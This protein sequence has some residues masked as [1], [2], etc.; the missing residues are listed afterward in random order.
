MPTWVTHMMI[1]DKVLEKFPQLDRHGFFVGNIAPDCNIQ[2]E[3]WTVYT[4]SR[5]KTHWM[6]G[7]R[8][9][10]SDVDTFCEEYI[11]KRRDE[12]SPGEEYSFLLGY[13]SHLI[14]DAVF[15]EM[16]LKEKRVAAVWARIK[17]DEELMQRFEQLEEKLEFTD[18]YFGHYHM[19]QRIDNKHMLLYKTIVKLEQKETDA[20]GIPRIGHPKYQWRN[21]VRFVFREE[22][23]EGIIQVVDA[24]GTFE[25]NEEPSYDILC[26]KKNCL[27]KHVLESEII[28]LM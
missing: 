5:E 15:Q 3:D 18:W 4:P 16:I 10:V 23:L 24:W 26:E 12:I 11:L 25:Q 14:T 20:T 8:K 17:A 27:Y 9:A 22:E 6:Q 19:D 13:Y 2:N 28:E 7:R 21:R 1:A